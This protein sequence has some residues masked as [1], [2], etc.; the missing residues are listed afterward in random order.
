MINTVVTLNQGCR[1]H[2]LVSGLLEENYGIL[3]SS[4]FMHNCFIISGIKLRYLN[5]L[6]H[7]IKTI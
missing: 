4:M 1:R 5:Y 7:H 6:K 3:E 2:S